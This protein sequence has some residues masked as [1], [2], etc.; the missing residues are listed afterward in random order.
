MMYDSFCKSQED[1]AKFFSIANNF[2][3]YMKNAYKVRFL[4][5]SK[6]K[7]CLN[8]FL[9]HF[10]FSSKALPKKLRDVWPN[11]VFFNINV[12]FKKTGYTFATM[13]F[14][15]D[16]RQ[17]FEIMIHTTSLVKKTLLDQ[18]SLQHYRSL[19]H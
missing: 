3:L 9:E 16:V 13:F 8:K 1:L 2:Q 11:D 6:Q 19:K 14:E 17:N 15:T 12:C 7:V 18:A 4:L 10:L 5:M